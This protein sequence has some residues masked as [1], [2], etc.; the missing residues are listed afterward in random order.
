[1]W[2]MPPWNWIYFQKHFYCILLILCVREKG[3]WHGTCV[4]VRWQLWES[5]SP[6]IVWVVDWIHAVRLGSRHL[7]GGGI[8]LVLIYLCMHAHVCMCMCVC[9]RAF[10]CACACVSV[11]THV[12]VCACV[13][14]CVLIC[15]CACVCT[16]V[17]ACVCVY[18]IWACQRKCVRV[19]LWEVLGICGL[20]EKKPCSAF[21]WVPGFWTQVLVLMWQALTGWA[22]STVLCWALHVLSKC[23][24]LKWHHQ[25]LSSVLLTADRC[26]TRSWV[27]VN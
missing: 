26:C 11:Y 24:S 18:V 25:P 13:S 10:M 8:L 1:M 3:T 19:P 14:V 22:I 23:S 21:S 4:E 9:V 5:V 27:S 7:Y 2:L 16:L 12:H 17:C 15:A 20:C 6:S